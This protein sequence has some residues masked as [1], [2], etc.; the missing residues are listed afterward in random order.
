MS[1]NEL[2][3]N[4]SV[5]LNFRYKQKLFKLSI[6]LDNGLLLLEELHQNQKELDIKEVISLNY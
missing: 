5:K 3:L 4:E 6:N 1:K 2:M